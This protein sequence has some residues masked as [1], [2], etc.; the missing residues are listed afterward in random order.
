MPPGTH[1]QFAAQAKQTRKLIDKLPRD[2]KIK[3]FIGEL[4]NLSAYIDADITGLLSGI[5]VP[6]LV[7][8]GDADTQVPFYLGKELSTQIKGARFVT[9]PGAGHGVMRW[10]D[11]VNEIKLFC[12]HLT[13]Q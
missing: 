2:E 9:I 10:P 12:D 5:N 4:L 7:V 1:R 6:T 8:H 13:G 3:Y 11:A